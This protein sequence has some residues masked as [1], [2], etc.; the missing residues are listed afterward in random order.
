MPEGLEQK[1]IISAKRP[2]QVLALKVVNCDAVYLLWKPAPRS[3][4]NYHS[5]MPTLDQALG[6]G[7]YDAFRPAQKMRMVQRVNEED[8][9]G[10]S[11]LRNRCPSQR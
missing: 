8:L 1:R 5:L 3:G 4:A 2:V 7:L 9:N 6:Q 10:Y 11:P